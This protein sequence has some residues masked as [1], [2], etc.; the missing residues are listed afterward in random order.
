MEEITQLDAE[1]DF[2]CQFEWIEVAS[3]F[4]SISVYTPALIAVLLGYIGYRLYKK[5]VKQLSAKPTWDKFE[6]AI[7]V[8]NSN[9]ITLEPNQTIYRNKFY[10]VVKT[11]LEPELGE[12][13]GLHL[14]IR[15]NER[16]AVRDWRH[17]QRIKNE[18]AGAEREAV[19]IFPPESQLVDTSNQY[20][21]WVLPEGTTS[22]FTWN[23]GRHVHNEAQDPET[24]E[25]LKSKG[26]DPAVIQNAVQRPYEEEKV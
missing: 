16:K 13:G 11:V 25:W 21:L 17:F 10:T 7:A 2:N 26:L 3:N 9:Q 23:E 15:H 8:V 5:W 4:F 22:F 18:L 1:C 14:S 20:H 6:E 12:K 19:E 24:I